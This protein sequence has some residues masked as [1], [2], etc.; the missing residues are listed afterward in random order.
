IC[1]MNMLLHGIMDSRIEKGDTMLE[2]KF[3]DNG[4]LMLFDRVIANPMWSQKGYGPET[5]PN[6][7]PF[8]RFQFGLAPKNS[9]DWGWIQH[10]LS[11]LNVSGRMVV[12]LDNGVL[13]RGNSEAEI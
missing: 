7:D 5:F 11:T 13:F 4:E 1:K 2:P 3:L 10:M 12:V 8:G 9:A 6:G